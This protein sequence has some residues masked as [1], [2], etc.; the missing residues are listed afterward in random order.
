MASNTGPRAVDVADLANSGSAGAAGPKPS[1]YELTTELHVQIVDLEQTQVNC[2]GVA[3][4][5]VAVELDGRE[6]ERVEIP[7]TV[8]IVAPPPSF[9]VDAS[10]PPGEHVLGIRD[11]STRRYVARTIRF[12]VVVANGTSIAEF[13]LVT[14]KAEELHIGSPEESSRLAL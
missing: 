1:V 12:P 2:D 7:C 6:I 4:R 13:L 9:D 5:Q 14:R 3:P 8:M 10:V 11:F